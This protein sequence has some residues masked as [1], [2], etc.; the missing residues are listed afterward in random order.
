VVPGTTG[1]GF[2]RQHL[3][4]ATL[5]FLDKVEHAPT[6]FMGRR[7]RMFVHDAYAIA[8][9][10]S[11]KETEIAGIWDPL[12][13]EDLAWAVRRGDHGLLAAVNRIL[14][15]WKKDGTL[16]KALDYWVP[17]HRRIRWD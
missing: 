4:D 7:I 16:T 10:V 12:T 15:G 13:D 11:E 5:V 6:F 17:I 9:L 2:A 8:W 14:A 3:P 1:E